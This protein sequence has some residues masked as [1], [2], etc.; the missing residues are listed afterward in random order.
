MGNGYNGYKN[1]GGGDNLLA[2]KVES[3]ECGLLLAR[4]VGDGVGYLGAAVE[5]KEFSASAPE[6]PKDLGLK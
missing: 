5:T 4:D 6:A 1:S 3:G 2:P